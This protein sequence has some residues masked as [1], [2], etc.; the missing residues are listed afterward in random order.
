MHLFYWGNRRNICKDSEF[1]YSRLQEIQLGSYFLGNSI[2]AHHFAQWANLLN[3]QIITNLLFLFIV[4]VCSHG[5]DWFPNSVK[6]VRWLIPELE[7]WAHWSE[8]YFY[9]FVFFSWWGI[10][11]GLGMRIS[12]TPL[13]LNPSQN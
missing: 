5:R 13:S 1:I 11:Q 3:M 12:R 6:T 4:L 2:C 10:L 8:W 7:R 9:F